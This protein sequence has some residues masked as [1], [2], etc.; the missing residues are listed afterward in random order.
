M[1][2]HTLAAA[3]L[4]I[5]F[6]ATANNSP[7]GQSPE[8]L[9]APNVYCWPGNQMAIARLAAKQGHAKFQPALSRL[10]MEADQELTGDLV[11][12]TDKPADLA[13]M[14]G[15]RNNYA[16]VS[17]YFWPDENDPKAPWVMKDG[18][19]NKDMIAK[20][21]GP[22][23]ATMQKRVITLALAYYFTG[24]E[25]YGR[26]AAD[27]LRAWFLDPA[28]RMNPH[29]EYAQ[30]VPN[31]SKG[32]PWGII[33]VNSFP[34][35]LDSVELLRGSP[36]WSAQ[37]DAG[38][39]QWFGEFTDWL[40]TSDLGQ[41]ERAFLNNHGTFYDLLVARSAIFSG[42]TDL[43][44]QIV[45]AYGD[46]RITTQIEPD[47]ST[48]HEQKRVYAAMYTCWNL[49]GMADMMLLARRLGIDLWSY[50]SPDGRSIKAAA[51]WLQPYVKDPSSWTFGDG[52]FKKTSPMEFFWMI[53]TTTQDPEITHFFRT[54][55]TPADRT[56]WQSNRWMLLAPLD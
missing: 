15:G 2:Q 48:P 31:K 42:K 43:A 50:Q 32:E 41:R 55:L 7:P 44:R 47:G 5:L 52:K 23:M 17:G 56:D 13:A 37:D 25:K 1:P 14:V 11:K 22:R 45:T 29:M 9:I 21:D 27:Q 39:Q 46:T 20:F 4:I 38:L 36:F 28:T 18:L 49:K 33:D 16:S 40:W 53:S 12:V 35:L 24:E 8:P 26:R 6:A 19:T 3:G 30:C 51:H 10:V 54:E 34:Y